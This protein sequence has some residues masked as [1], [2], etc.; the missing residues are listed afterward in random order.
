MNEP[1]D[2]CTGVESLTPQPIANRP[3]LGS[4]AYRAGTHA[5]FLATMQ[6][7]LSGASRP[8]L[9]GLRTREA[10]DPSIALL[11]A[12]ATVA[13][14]LTFYQERLANEGYLGTATE[15]RSVL[16]LARLIGYTPRPGV[17]STVYL[18]YTMEK[19]AI[20]EV[21]AGSRAQSVPGPGE[22]PQSFETGETIAARAEWNNLQPRMAIPQQITLANV[23]LIEQVYFAGTTTNLKLNDQLLF[24]FGDQV[25]HQALR[26]VQ[27]IQPDFDANRTRVM[28][29]PLPPFHR[30]LDDILVRLL[31][32]LE[33]VPTAPQEFVQSGLE[34]IWS[35][36]QPMFL[37]ISREGYWP[38][39]LDYELENRLIFSEGPLDQATIDQIVQL[40]KELRDLQEKMDDGKI[41]PPPKPQTVNL[42]D[43]IGPL[44][45]PPSI[46]P[47]NSQRLRRS[48]DQVFGKDTDV[49]PQLLVR[50]NP[51]LETTLYRAWANAEVSRSDTQPQAISKTPLQ[52]AYVFRQAAALF[53]TRAIKKGK[54]TAGELVNIHEWP[55]TEV[56]GTGTAQ[57]RTHHE[58]PSIVNLDGAN[59]KILAGS[60][61]VVVTDNTSLTDEQVQIAK[62]ANPRAGISRADYGISGPITR[63]SL[64]SP[65]DP[66]TL[67]TWI[68]TDLSTYTPNNDDD[69]RAIR[70]TTVYAQ[71]EALPLADQPHNDDVAGATIELDR[72]YEGLRSGRWIVVT[73]E[74]SDIPGTTGVFASELAMVTG[75]S[76]TPTRPGDKTH[77]TLALFAP[78]A[79]RFK[80]ATVTIAGNVAKAT[81][82]ETREET[83]GSGDA[84]QPFQ[85]FT[86]RQPPLTYVAAP[87]PS[88]AASTLHVYVNSVEWHEA[89]D[90]LGLGPA[91]RAFI[92]R[93]DDDSTTTVVFGEG[94]RGARLPTGVENVRAKYRNG[95]GKSG[96][97]KAEQISLL[98]TRPLGVKAVINPLQASGGADKETRDQ[99]RSTAPLSTLALDRLVSVQDY[100][101][102]ARMF[103]GI[104]KATAARLSDGQRML[105]HVTIAG[106]DDIP[107]DP[108]SDLFQNLRRALRQYGDSHMPVQLALR[109]ALALVISAK[110]RLLPDYLWEDVEQRVRKRLLDTFGFE[111][112]DMGQPTYLSQ[113]ISA[114]Q[115][116]EGVAY[117]D[118]DTFSGI[119]EN[120]TQADLDT[121]RNSKAPEP[122]VRAL[123]ARLNRDFNAKTDTPDRRLLPAQLAFLTP[124]VPD[125][126]ILKE[127][128]S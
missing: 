78:L 5:E 77:T 67:V 69:F 96:N 26:G 103:A 45:R 88:G 86:L 13:D 16:E 84:S 52:A 63:I 41:E 38:D 51:A 99:A 55:V 83:L 93:T 65:S 76:Q 54:I 49:L 40:I 117:V 33:A 102:F 7:R 112:R 105:V 43:L 15:R 29:Q 11:D 123:L 24:V 72:L 57:Q 82:G 10:D 23:L 127:L 6:A 1:C 4:L 34:T 14:V 74:R 128:P 89:P 36:R 25:G 70:Q 37:A 46:Q 64:A 114:I 31:S 109:G 115:A 116:V 111:R 125:T 62:A 66:E 124:S 90:L 17:A 106:A 79:F 60:W 85:S 47:R 2:C 104:G 71:S 98:S 61:L 119:S 28:L 121:L 56:Q 59:D 19:D 81:H 27:L 50:F 126:L 75:V 92:T 53:G 32:I 122:A 113:V 97:A 39:D 87:I 80:R 42:S 107:I 94:Q 73:G 18:S 21:P 12:W 48:L 101:D 44:L 68:T 35:A 20:G 100:A 30:A 9:A 95:I 91:D 58:H 118:V 120:F 108:S 3:G 22:L 110:I 8:E